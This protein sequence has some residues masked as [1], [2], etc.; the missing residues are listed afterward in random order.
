[1]TF[2]E[3]L[4]RLGFNTYDD[5]LS[6]DHWQRFKEKYRKSGLPLNCAV[7]HQGPIQLHHHTYERLGQESLKDVDPLCH[8]HHESVHEYLKQKS[9]SLRKTADA[10]NHLRKLW[11]KDK[12]TPSSKDA[13]PKKKKKKRQRTPEELEERRT[14][15]KRNREIRKVAYLKSTNFR[16]SVRTVM[17]FDPGKQYASMDIARIVQGGIGFLLKKKT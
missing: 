14:R 3:R 1:M 4:C 2:K 12:P 10:I 9:L 13:T 11:G 16:K 7:C 15:R 5:Y 6:S 17:N 8:I